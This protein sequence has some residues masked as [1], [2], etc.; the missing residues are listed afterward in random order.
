MFSQKIILQVILTLF[1]VYFLS[2]IIKIDTI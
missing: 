2:E 1:M